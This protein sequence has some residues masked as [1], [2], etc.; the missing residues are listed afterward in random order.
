M[1]VGR[2][3]REEKRKTPPVCICNC[4]YKRERAYFEGKTG[5]DLYRNPFVL[6]WCPER[7]LNPHNLAV[8]G[9]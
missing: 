4:N 3:R 9:F 2:G 6:F 8:Q 7:G 5:V 1:E